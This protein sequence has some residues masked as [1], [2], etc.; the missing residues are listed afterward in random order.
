MIRKLLFAFIPMFF[1]QLVIAQM[2]D[3][4]VSQFNL[5]FAVPDIPAFKALDIDPSDIVRPSDPK[6]I[7]L[8]VS[9][10]QNHGQFVIPQSFA[11]EIAPGMLVSPKMTLKEYQQSGI[12]R[13]LY[14]ARISIGTMRDDNSI[15]SMAGGVRFTLIDKG[16]FRNDTA[17]LRKNI[18]TPLDSL[19]E[20]TTKAKRIYI[21]KYNTPG[22]PTVDFA[23]PK[24]IVIRDS[25][26]KLFYKTNK[27]IIDSIN[28][29]IDQSI[30]KYKKENWN[31]ARLEMAYALVGTSPDSLGKNLRS[32]KHSV[33]L[34][35][36]FP[37]KAW[38]QFLIGANYQ[39]TLND[40]A[41]FNHNL[42]AA[43]RFYAGGNRLKAF[44]EGEYKYN[45]FTQINNLL[46]CMGGE[47]NIRDGIWLHFSAGVENALSGD[48]SSQFISSFNLFL[49]LPE[50][51]RIF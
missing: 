24:F 41:Y 42:N 38:G 8:M 43:T 6:A 12:N 17:F 2:E 5:N 45:D 23:S 51:F 16:D 1:C 11:A 15:S 22:D 13:F 39:Y 36:A 40:S 18:Y 33:W 21:K 7:S 28:S 44:V 37:V 10:F 34:I 19:T 26:V 31:K 14:K 3:S 48:A 35:G 47:V 9:Q 32:T 4:T 29:S 30:E 46:V 49:T 50:T 25:L 20:I 27:N